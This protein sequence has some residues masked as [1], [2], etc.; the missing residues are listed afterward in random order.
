ME[1]VLKFIPEGAEEV[2]PSGF[3][4]ERGRKLRADSPRRFRRDE[5]TTVRD[6]YREQWPRLVPARVLDV[7]RQLLSTQELLDAAS[8][9]DAAALL[10]WDW[11]V[12]YWTPERGRLRERRR[13]REWFDTG[14]ELGHGYGTFAV[15]R[16]CVVEI[17][18][19]LGDVAPPEENL[20]QRQFQDTVKALTPKLS[21]PDGNEP[22]P[23]PQVHW[24]VGDGGAVLVLTIRDDLLMLV[25][26]R[27][28]SEAESRGRLVGG[29]VMARLRSALSARR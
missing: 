7:A 18:V 17:A 16:G 9:D 10:G 19:A 5:L 23:H 13:E 15:H 29:S 28:R 3:W 25:S 11:I 24:V 8:P 1:E 14:L 22:G 27:D 6:G 12:A 20:R 26:R 4:S 2:P 21:E